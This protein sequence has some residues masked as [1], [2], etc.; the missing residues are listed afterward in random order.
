M[1][2]R[3]Y[4]VCLV[5]ILAFSACWKDVWVNIDIEN[6]VLEINTML[7]PDSVIKLRLD[8]TSYLNGMSFRELNQQSDVRLW[9]NDE[10]KESLRL[11][12]DAEWEYFYF[13][14]DY[15]LRETDRVRLEAR[16]KGYPDAWVETE[17]PSL[18]PID[19]FITVLHNDTVSGRIWVIIINWSIFVCQRIWIYKLRING[20]SIIILFC[21]DIRKPEFTRSPYHLYLVS[22]PVFKYI[23]TTIEYLLGEEEE[24]GTALFFDDSYI[25]GRTYSIRFSLDFT[26]PYWGGGYYGLENLDSLK[27][28]LNFSSESLSG[29][30]SNVSHWASKGMLEGNL[31]E[32]GLADPVSAYSNV[33]QGTGFVWGLA[34]A[35]WENT[36]PFPK[37]SISE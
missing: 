28:L 13:I 23:P 19:T 2:S 27:L 11:E 8:A 16:C 36:L 20:K 15:R 29:Y 24:K 3:L 18:V 12:H 26:N 4:L 30:Y 35:V 32:V 37:D 5:C 17:V 1:K 6:P 14:S 34:M 10:F 7:V 21:R 22:D 25:D 33:H 31:S 9:V